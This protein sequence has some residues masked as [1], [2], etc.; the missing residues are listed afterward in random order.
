MKSFKLYY[1]NTYSS[2]S[3]QTHEK[4]VPNNNIDTTCT[5][6]ERELICY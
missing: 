5:A 6:Q 2:N 1:E 4:N 3:V